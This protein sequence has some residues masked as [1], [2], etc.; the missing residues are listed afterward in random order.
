MLPPILTGGDAEQFAELAGKVIAV[1]EAD[2]KRNL[3]DARLGAAEQRSPPVHAQ[4][5]DIGNG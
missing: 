5:D 3:G 4:L 1:V 2:L